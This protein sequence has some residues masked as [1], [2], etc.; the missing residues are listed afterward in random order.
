MRGVRFGV[1]VLWLAAIAAGCGSSASSA[2]PV[3]SRAPSPSSSAASAAATSDTAGEPTFKMPAGGNGTCAVSIAGA[4]T[5]S[6]T[7][8]QDMGTLQVSQWL[9]ASS[10]SMLNLNPGDA[11]FILN[12]KGDAVS[13]NFTTVDGTT[14]AMFPVA[15][16]DHVIG[17]NGVMGGG[18]PGQMSAMVN[19]GDKSIWRV[20]KPGTFSITKFG[21]SK[22]AGTFSFA[23]TSDAG[24][25]TV[26]GS[27]DLSCT[28]DACS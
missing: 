10:R 1:A 13:V 27:F 20:A 22:L 16:G 26:T 11:W 19:L 9:S 18:S 5:K 3:G 21:G 15:P 14:E 25:A 17:Q 28:G 12:C 2:G 24:G 8:T 23:I 7:T 4:V 6:W